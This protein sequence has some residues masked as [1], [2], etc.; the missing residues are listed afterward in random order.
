MK[1]R[2]IFKFVVLYLGLSL[3]ATLVLLLYSFPNYPKSLEGWTW[4]FLLALPISLVVEL[5]G[6]AIWRNPVANSIETRTAERRFSWLRVCYGLI[7]M[8]LFFG[9]SWG[10]SAYFGVV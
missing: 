8:L 1:I 5:F 9:L 4:L 6:V 3:L 10:M 7:V 2:R